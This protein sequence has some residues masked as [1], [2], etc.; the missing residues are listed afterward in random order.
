MGLRVES[1]C[2]SLEK[3]LFIT[4]R[5]ELHHLVIM[6]ELPKPQGGTGDLIA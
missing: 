5:R 1:K 3:V 2:P 4:W 6:F